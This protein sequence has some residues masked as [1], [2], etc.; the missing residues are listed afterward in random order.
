[1]T[2]VRS[3]TAPDLATEGLVP[4]HGRV[5]DTIMIDETQAQFFMS[6]GRTRSLFQGIAQWPSLE[7]ALSER[8]L[9]FLRKVGEEQWAAAGGVYGPD[10]TPTCLPISPL[11]TGL[12]KDIAA[13]PGGLLWAD[14]QGDAWAV[15]LVPAGHDPDTFFGFALGWQGAEPSPERTARTSKK[16]R[17]DKCVDI[18][19]P[20]E[21]HAQRLRLAA[22]A[23]QLLWVIHW[24]V[25]TQRRSVVL[26]PD[27]LLG[28]VVWGGDRGQWPQDWRRDLFLTLRSLTHLR[29]EVLRLSV[30]GWRPQ[31]GLHSVAVAAV[32]Q[33]WVTRPGDDYCR[34]YCP[35]WRTGQPHRHFV[36]QAG[37][38]FLGAMERFAVDEQP[39]YRTYDF[40]PTRL[41]DNASGEEIQDARK[42]G[43]LIS[44]NGPAALFSR[45]KWAGLTEAHWRISRA[46]GREVT[47]PERPGKSSRQDAA[48]VL[49]G[50]RVPGL[51]PKS[52]TVCPKL[53]PSGRYVAFCGNGKRWGM[54]YQILGAQGTGWLRKCGYHV[55]QDAGELVKVTRNFLDDLR[56]VCE[57]LGL[58]VVGL[59]PN[60]GGWL[61]LEDMVTLA[62][63]KAG[64]GQ[65]LP[66]HLRVYGPEDYL[67]RWRTYFAEKGGF[68][69]I[70]GDDGRDT[71]LDSQKHL[72]DFSTR[73]RLA[74]FKQVELARRL[75]VSQPF[76]SQ[77]LNNDRPWP[78]SVQA[79]AEAILQEWTRS[80]GLF[81]SGA[82]G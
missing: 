54:G 44:V 2:Q 31:L 61:G 24:A 6:L 42:T 10:G 15:R 28:Q 71:Q 39:G 64:V 53:S 70:P 65:L 13:G 60:A 1:M 20:L 47:R 32:E 17:N 68:A 8:S 3:T 82:A 66:V 9:E 12:V 80:A 4:F 38:G 34:D 72:G 56:E 59:G 46:L 18:R 41:P 77:L 14:K 29:L 69:H 27:A 49:K 67:R 7:E 51:T 74:G 25:L 36:V 63:S 26:L 21:Q 55:S 57:V 22:R 75:G 30:E 11:A 62:G 23:E 50:N 79:R 48:H 5:A 76:V 16:R 43:Q 35:M 58:T 73:I 52:R 19:R 45:S 81:D 78:P 37:Y 40:S 33:L